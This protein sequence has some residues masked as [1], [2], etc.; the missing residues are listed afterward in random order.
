MA[1][2]FDAAQALIDQASHLAGEDP[3]GRAAC[4]IEHGR[5]YNSAGQRDVA[6]PL[7]HEAWRLAREARAHALAVDA[8]H[9]IAI[10]GTLDDAIEWTATA[11]AYVGE[12]PEA[13]AWRGPLLNNLGWNYFDAGRFEDAL[14]IFRQATDVR[15]QQGRKLELRIAFHAVVTT[16]RA[17]G[18]I[19][20]A[21][22]L[23]EEV[24]DAAE[25]EGDQAPYMREEL[26]ECHARLGD[27][28][29]ARLSARRALAILEGR[30]LCHPGASPA[31][32]IAGTGR[33]SIGHRLCL[34]TTPPDPVGA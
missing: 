9:M 7:F 32:Q 10:A 2:D 33:L 34:G 23:A 31:R 1:G 28:D 24:A 29:R 4:A 16:L 17:L 11:L 6:R 22:L 13:E 27:M 18:R 21:R 20:E 15:H 12:H 3:A 19:E 25:A 8:A 5:L 26:A 30:R 14:P